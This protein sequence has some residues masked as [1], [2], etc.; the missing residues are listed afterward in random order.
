M[1]IL[2]ISDLHLGKRVKEFSMLNDQKYILEQILKTADSENPDCIVIAGDIYDKSIPPAEAVSIFDDFICKIAERKIPAFI[3]SGNHDSPER[4]AFGGRLMPASGIHIAPVYNGRI[5]PIELSD[6]YGIVRFYMIPFIRPADVRHIYP[7]L[8]IDSYTEALRNIIEELEIDHSF[9]NVLI[10]HQFVSGASSLSSEEFL[11][12]G[13]EIV[14]SSVFADFDYT[15][16]GHIHRAQTAGSP[17]IRYCGSQLAYHIDEADKEKTVTIAEL[18]KKG[19]LEIRTVPLVPK[20]AVHVYKGLYSQLTD[21]SFYEK[22]CTDDYV[23]LV[24]TDEED[25]PDAIHKLRKV[26]PNIFGLLYD[27][28]RTNKKSVIRSEIKN[29]SLPPAEIF[30]RFYEE[31]CGHS[32]TGEQQEFVRS[33][34][35]EV[36]EKEI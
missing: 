2:H 13:T 4:I 20:R 32:M 16:L 36:W 18:R 7:D 1:K 17:K 12:G 29:E 22:C 24:L 21:K 28:S 3:I 33:L 30:S 19:E 14:E 23:Y 9:R 27:N 15:A 31:Q 6:Q 25:I 5:T 26:Y 8:K 11:V 34:I 35:K 10:T